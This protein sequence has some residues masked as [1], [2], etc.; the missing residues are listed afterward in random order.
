MM[1]ARGLPVN[2]HGYYGKEMHGWRVSE[3]HNAAR[4]LFNIG[5]DGD[6]RML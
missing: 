4:F 1:N 3:R 2:M 5:G 6:A